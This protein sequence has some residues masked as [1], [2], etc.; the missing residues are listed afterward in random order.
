MQVRIV[1]VEPVTVAALEHR[2]APALL[3]DSVQRFIAWRKE[4]GLSP[5]ND[6]GTYGIA[7]DDPATTPA[8][9]FRFDICGAVGAPVPANGHG[10]ITKSI[11]GGRCAVV[12][13]KGSPDH[14][15]GSVYHLYRNWLPRSGEEPRDFPVYFHYLNLR[16]DTPEHELLTDVHL[17]LR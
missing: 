7:W 13:H 16:T 3:N 1:T 6:N 8:D 9:E 2:G 14:I 17:P 4:T 12:R 10:V 5:V 15:S 11:P